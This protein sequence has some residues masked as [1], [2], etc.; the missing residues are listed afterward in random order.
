MNKL[1]IISILCL[2]STALLIAQTDFIYSPKGE[3]IIFKVRTDK[4]LLETSDKILRS[5]LPKVGSLDMAFDNI[6]VATI[7][8]TKQ[9]I[10]AIK[11]NP[12]IKKATNLLEYSDGTLQALTNEIFVQCENQELIE[13]SLNI[14]G[15]KKNVVKIETIIPED[16]IFL[17]TFDYEVTD[18]MEI[19]RGLYESGLVE[20]AEPSFLRFNILHNEFYSDQWGLRNNGIYGGTVNMD[21]NILPAWEITRGQN[22]RVAVIDDGVDLGHPDLNWNLV[23]GY[24][25]V[26]TSNTPG[27]PDYYSFHGTACAG[28]IGALDNDIG[29]VGVAPEC[30]II[31]IRAFTGNT[32]YQSTAQDSH[33]ITAIRTAWETAQA[34]VISCS[35]GKGSEFTTFTSAI[36]QA[37][38]QGRGGKGCVVVVSSG[39][40]KDNE[41]VSVKHPA[42]LDNVLT[43]G[44]MDPC[45]K[46]KSPTSCDGEKWGSCYGNELNVVAPGVLIATTDIRESNG[47]NSR[48]PIHTNL[49]GSKRTTDYSHNNYTAWFN[50]TSAACPHVSGI[51]ALILSANPELT[52]VQVR[53]IIE[54]S[55]DKL[56]GYIYTQKTNGPWHQEIGYGKVNAYKALEKAVP[57]KISGPTLIGS[58]EELF[59]ISNTS[60][61]IVVWRCS[62]NLQLGNKNNTSA[63]LKAKYSGKGWIQANVNGINTPKFEIW[64]GAPKIERITGPSTAYVGEY[65]KFT[66]EY[67]QLSQASNFEWKINPPSGGNVYGTNHIC[68]IALYQEGSFQIVVRASNRF[69][70][71][72]Y[73]TSGLRVMNKSGYSFLVYPNP[74]SDVLIIDFNS[75][76]EN[77]THILKQNNISKITYDIY[78]Y[79]LMGS[80]VRSLKSTDQQQ[81]QINVS[82]LPNGYYYLI[83]DDKSG[84]EPEKHTIAIRH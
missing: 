28:I 18:M 56:S 58:S 71:G 84:N 49:G 68:D 30:K 66:A 72:D 81:V 51:A 78:L 61:K 1:F 38:T 39:N 52:Q 47:Y 12:Y 34:D 14:L 43:V 73:T 54:Q 17:I 62:D 70:Y 7:D 60:G 55:C 50:G 33:I 64:G 10:K 11:D 13:K 20:F 8:S 63:L 75:S 29:V 32:N 83:I 59:S 22:I 48:I 35:W 40:Y 4:V 57:Y 24:D 80:L 6:F 19:C 31:P 26:S 9:T 74:V 25:V 2:F 67:N 77:S 65:A 36:N 5:Q 41:S 37:T 69:G 15:I 23:R 53:N 76:N 44:A 27:A 82:D 42:R 3:K 16:H 46:R 79:N 45:G 21:I